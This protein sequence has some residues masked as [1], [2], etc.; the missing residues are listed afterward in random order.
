LSIDHQFDD[1]IEAANNTTYPLHACRLCVCTTVEYSRLKHEEER[2]IAGKMLCRTQNAIEGRKWVLVFMF[3]A[4]LLSTSTA[5]LCPA[6]TGQS[7]SSFLIAK[8][9][10]EGMLCVSSTSPLKK[11]SRPKR[12]VVR[13][14][15]V[16]LQQDPEFG[17]GDA[18]LSALLEEGDVVAFVEGT[19]EV[20][21]V[22]VGDGTPPRIS[23]AK[24]DHLQII[25]THNC[26]HGYIRGDA[27]EIVDN[28]DD[29]LKIQTMSDKNGE[30]VDIGPEQ[31]EARIASV[32]WRTISEVDSII[33][34]TTID[35]DV[36]EGLLSK[37]EL[38]E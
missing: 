1:N 11:I 20:D 28:D 9:K 24:V 8:S 7:H 4:Q 32:E 17:R 35:R 33:Q 13:H 37:L 18:H 22:S 3:M 34:A 21:G 31:L 23:F 26:E 16:Q 6:I 36:Y 14:A 38:V 30:L 29:D 12:Q 2:G 25:W 19:W 5:W 10:F 15:S 27:L